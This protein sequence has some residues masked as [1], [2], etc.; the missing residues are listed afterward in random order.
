MQIEDFASQQCCGS[1]DMFSPSTQSMI[2]VSIAA[3]LCAL[4]LCKIVADVSPVC[5]N[6][7]VSFDLRDYSTQ[8]HRLVPDPDCSVCGQSSA[9]NVQPIELQSCIV[10][11]HQDGGHRHISPEDTLDRFS[12]LISPITGVVGHLQTIPTPM[13]SVHVVIAGRNSAQQVNTLNDLRRN[14]RSAAGVKALP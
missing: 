2:G 5:D 1:E 13:R 3:Q 14:L 11:F 9:T 8:Y 12:E 7:V 4:E 10:N 6:Q